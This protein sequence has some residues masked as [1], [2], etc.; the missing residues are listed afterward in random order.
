[1]AV[2]LRLALITYKFYFNR[3][4]LKFRKY[5]IFNFNPLFLKMLI[6]GHNMFWLSTLDVMISRAENQN[7]LCPLFLKWG[8]LHKMVHVSIYF[9]FKGPNSY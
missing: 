5:Y 2:G 6:C 9:M 8:L 1:M 7:K 4:E 3:F